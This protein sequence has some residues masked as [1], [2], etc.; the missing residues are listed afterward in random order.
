M[1][2]QKIENRIQQSLF[3]QQA[4]V[5][6]DPLQNY[7]VSIIS[8]DEEAV[9]KWASEHSITGSYSDILKHAKTNAFILQEI[10]T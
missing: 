8:A 9:T 6:G 3:V 5:Y 1:C 4:F 10:Q 2:P 7:I